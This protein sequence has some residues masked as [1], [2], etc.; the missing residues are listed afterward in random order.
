MIVRVRK[1]VLL[2]ILSPCSEIAMQL[3]MSLSASIVTTVLDYQ[4]YVTLFMRYI[5]LNN[6]QIFCCGDQQERLDTL[7]VERCVP[8]ACRQACCEA[9][10]RQSKVIY[11]GLSHAASLVLVLYFTVPYLTPKYHA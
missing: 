10:V 4:P 1:C 6:Q 3:C 9:M 8:S 7:V 11:G 5:L 2:K